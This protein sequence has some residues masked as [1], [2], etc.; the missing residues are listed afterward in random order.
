MGVCPTF[1]GPE[2]YAISITRNRGLKLV[3]TDNVGGGAKI[4]LQGEAFSQGSGTV[5]PTYT[6]Y[7]LR[8]SWAISLWPVTSF[9]AS[10]PGDPGG[11]ATAPRQDIV[12]VGRVTFHGDGSLGGHFIA[13]TDDNAGN[14]YY[15]YF[16]D[17]SVVTY[18]RSQPQKLT[19]PPLK[20]PL[21]E[22]D[23]TISDDGR[24]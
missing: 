22:G 8:R 15:Y 7:S 11:V 18:A 20:V 17:E 13:T 4:F 1:E 23:V 16:S 14:T 6:L 21:N 19:D 2:T 12:R 3:Q 5:P 24:S 10:A 9:A